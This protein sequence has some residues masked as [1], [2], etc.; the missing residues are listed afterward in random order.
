MADRAPGLL[1]PYTGPDLINAR[2]NIVECIVDGVPRLRFVSLEGHVIILKTRKIGTKTSV[3]L[4][5]T[6]EILDTIWPATPASTYCQLLERPGFMLEIKVEHTD[7]DTTSVYYVC[8]ACVRYPKLDNASKT[9]HIT[10][11]VSQNP[12][13][14]RRRHCENS[15]PHAR[16]VE[17]ILRLPTAITF[18]S[19]ICQ[20]GCGKSFP[21]EN[22]R[23]VHEVKKCPLR[24][25][26]SE[27]KSKSKSKPK[28]KSKTKLQTTSKLGATAF[29]QNEASGSGLPIRS[30]SVVVDEG[31]ASIV[32]SPSVDNEPSKRKRDE[33]EDEEQPKPKRPRSGNCCSPTRSPT[34]G[35][36]CSTSGPRSDVFPGHVV[37]DS[38]LEI[39]FSDSAFPLEP[40]TS[41]QDLEANFAP[42]TIRSEI[43]PPLP[44]LAATV[45]LHQG[46]LADFS[47]SS[48]NYAS[49]LALVANIADSNVL[50]HSADFWWHDLPRTVSPQDLLANSAEDTSSNH[51]FTLT[52]D[53]SD[54]VPILPDDV[55]CDILAAAAASSTEQA[56][57]A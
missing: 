10:L 8:P 12:L 7:G 50:A 3:E 21:R 6:P 16:N 25:N 1:I 44:T 47:Q 32:H 24:P 36:S 52:Q 51:A 20:L 48:F 56:A 31:Y 49:T 23:K 17:E 27:P 14:F 55:W 4:F 53:A 57:Q 13:D 29:S 43:A 41:L 38:S 37:S 15:L 9:Y 45:T 34:P 19:H 42:E 35:P 46:L 40:L 22:F 30:P 39:A 11:S 5:A 26:A 28:S 2:P 18:I 33:G 54:Y